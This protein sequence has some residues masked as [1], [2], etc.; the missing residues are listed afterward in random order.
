M[1][2][3]AAWVGN[4]LFNRYLRIQDKKVDKE[5]EIEKE[6]VETKQVSRKHNWSKTEDF[7]LYDPEEEES[8]DELPP[9]NIKGR[10]RR[11]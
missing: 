9:A 6:V 10:R 1:A 3:M 5:Y 7:G 11:G 2:Y 4:A 8:E